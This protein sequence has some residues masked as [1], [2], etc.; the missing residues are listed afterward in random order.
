M[1]PPPAWRH[2]GDHQPRCR[3]R[4]QKRRAD[5][6]GQETVEGFL[7]DFEKGLGPVE[8]GI[9]D[10]DVE[11]AETGKGVAERGRVGHVERQCPRPPAHSCDVA[12]HL[13]KLACRSADQHQLGAGGGKRQR[14]GAADPTPGAGDERRLAV[15]AK[16]LIGSRWHQPGISPA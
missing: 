1:T 13:F 12:R 7:I 16:G 9:V 10:Q 5:V 15:E 3:L 2:L 6:E 8:A 4:H 11:A 14:H